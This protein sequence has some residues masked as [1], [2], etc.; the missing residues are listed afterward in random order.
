MAR[1]ALSTAA[2][3]NKHN[4]SAPLVKALLQKAGVTPVTSTSTATREYCTWPFREA[5]SVLREY[6]SK[7]AFR[8]HSGLADQ[9]RVADNSIVSNPKLVKALAKPADIKLE[10]Q[11]LKPDR[12]QAWPFPEPKFERGELGDSFQKAFIYG[13]LEQLAAE[14]THLAATLKLR[15]AR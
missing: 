2:L 11:K 5:N 13:R 7:V 10:K 8:R 1:K 14:L 3:G 15:A 12:S 4:I 6:R 9:L